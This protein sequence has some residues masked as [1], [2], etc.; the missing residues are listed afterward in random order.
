[1]TDRTEYMSLYY[2]EN[3]ERLN[4]AKR[5][6]RERNRAEREIN[7]SRLKLKDWLDKQNALQIS[8]FE[9]RY[10][11]EMFS[12]RYGMAHKDI[13]DAFIKASEIGLFS[14]EF[15]KMARSNVEKM[16]FLDYLQTNEIGNEN[17]LTDLNEYFSK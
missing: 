15:H 3:K 8:T 17:V 5:Q 14:V 16:K 7:K 4:E 11:I 12:Q 1:M 6:R 13:R 9:D 10:E 2:D